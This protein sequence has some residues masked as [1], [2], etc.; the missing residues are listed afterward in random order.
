MRR[1]KNK[2]RKSLIQ[3]A[4]L[5][6][7]LVAV[8]TVV[9]IKTHSSRA[10]EHDVAIKAD[11]QACL[12]KAQNTEGSEPVV[13]KEDSTSVDNT[14]VSEITKT[15]TPPTPDV[16]TGNESATET[17]RDCYERYNKAIAQSKEELQPDETVSPDVCAVSSDGSA[18]GQDDACIRTMTTTAKD[19]D[20][21]IEDGDVPVKRR[22]PDDGEVVALEPA[23]D[24]E[25]VRR[26]SEAPMQEDNG[27][28]P[29]GCTEEPCYHTTTSTESTTT[30]APP[31]A[32]A[33]P[34]AAQDTSLTHT[35]QL[36]GQTISIPGVY[37][38]KL[39]AEMG[40]IQQLV[41]SQIGVGEGQ[42]VVLGDTVTLSATSLKVQTPVGEVAIETSGGVAQLSIPNL[43]VMTDETVIVHSGQLAL[44]TTQGAVPLNLLPQEL[45]MVPELQGQDIISAELDVMQ[46]VPVYEVSALDQERLFGL[47]PVTFQTTT[48]IDAQTREVLD[49]VGPWWSFLS[50]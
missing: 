32:P 28:V 39:A 16:R 35:I 25:A 15:E 31:A 11:L 42:V 22:P 27:E 29:V 47:I 2:K 44:T 34:P 3:E 30:P 37:F 8:A 43:N 33:A 13:V 46:N 4:V 7:V 45:P 12:E 49:V 1:L 17:E 24:N 9:I 40:R 21:P 14:G 26:D 48:F 18:S 20:R 10:S 23:P 6:A 41:S 50:F 36:N 5:V 19:G 38:D